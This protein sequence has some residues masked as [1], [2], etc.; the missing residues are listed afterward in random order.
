M[1]KKILIVDDE[2]NNLQVLRQILKERYRLLFAPS[3][4]KASHY[5]AELVERYG[6][7]AESYQLRYLARRAIRSRDA[8]QA[9]DLVVRS[10]RKDWHIALHEPLRTAST[11]SCYSIVFRYLSTTAW[12]SAR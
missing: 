5:A 6:N 11:V 9:L 10:L 12:S 7:L 4:E 8:A 2:P 3:G 1:P